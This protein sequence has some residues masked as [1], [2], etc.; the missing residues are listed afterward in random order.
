MLLRKTKMPLFIK[1]FKTQNKYENI[2][3]DLNKNSQKLIRDSLKEEPR[4]YLLTD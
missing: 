2:M 3:I 1:E 4:D